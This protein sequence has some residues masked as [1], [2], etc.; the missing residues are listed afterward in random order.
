MYTSWTSQQKKSAFTTNSLYKFEKTASTFL[1]QLLKD[2]EVT[3]LLPLHDVLAVNVMITN[4]EVVSTTTPT[5]FAMTALVEFFYVGKEQV[6]DLSSLLTTVV[7]NYKGSGLYELLNDIKLIDADAQDFVYTFTN[8]EGSS[9]TRTVY[10]IH[11]DEAD[12]MIVTPQSTGSKKNGLI[13]FVVLL[14][15]S[16]IMVSSVLLWVSGGCI[17]I[18]RSLSWYLQNGVRMP[19]GIDKGSDGNETVKTDPSG[20]L[21]AASNDDEENKMPTG[22]SPM[23][24]LYRDDND[25]FSPLSNMSNTSVL[26]TTVNN[27]P[28]GIVSMRK[29]GAQYGTPEKRHIAQF[30]Q[31]PRLSYSSEKK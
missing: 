29:L 31:M 19:Y 2:E 26:T 15:L 25:M 6:Q 7:S 18:K 1:T 4:Q 20:I 9:A 13:V 11:N 21:G 28:L 16:L 14:I 22:F 27:N 17:C 8:P 12:Y 30:A 24:G 23:R 10:T 5:T 3:G